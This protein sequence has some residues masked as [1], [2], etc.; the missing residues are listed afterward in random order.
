[1]SAFKFNE[2]LSSNSLLFSLASEIMLSLVT[3]SSAFVS[4]D[5]NFPVFWVLPLSQTLLFISLRLLPFYLPITPSFTFI[6]EL[7]V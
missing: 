3:L 4:S 7:L 5:A 6:N 2:I 1:M